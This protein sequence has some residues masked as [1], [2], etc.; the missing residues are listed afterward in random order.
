MGIILSIIGGLIVDAVVWE[1][2]VQRYGHPSVG[3]T[4]EIDGPVGNDL[5]QILSRCPVVIVVV[6]ASGRSAEVYV[7]NECIGGG[8]L[9]IKGYFG[10]AARRVVEFVGCVDSL[11]IRVVVKVVE[12][13]IIR[14]IGSRSNGYGCLGNSNGRE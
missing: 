2:G 8:V 4:G 13:Y 1:R 12:W 3:G 7:G 10:D 5:G 14:S 6:L 9:A 11:V